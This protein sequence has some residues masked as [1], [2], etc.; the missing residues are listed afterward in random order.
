MSS[1]TPPVP[2]R[3]SCDLVNEPFSETEWLI[4]EI[5]PKNSL[6]LF[7]G[8]EGSMKTW[9]AL[10]WAFSVAEGTPWLTRECQ[11]AAVLYLDA[12]NPYQ[13]F[14]QRVGAISASQNWN[15]W[16]WQDP[17]FPVSLADSQLLA[18][19]QEHRLIIIDSLRR[20]MQ[21]REENSA[22]EMASI[23][24]QLR[25]LTREGATVL[26]LHHARK[27]S[28]NKGYR[29]STELGAGVDI[30]MHI[31]Q[32]ISSPVVDKLEITVSKTRYHEKRT[33]SLE[34]TTTSARPLFQETGSSSVSP[35]QASDT[36]LEEIAVIIEN[37][38]ASSEAPPTQTQIA[39]EAHLKGLGS[40]NTVRRRLSQGEGRYWHSRTNGRTRVYE[41]V[42]VSTCP[43]SGQVDNTSPH[44][45]QP[46]HVSNPRDGGQVDN[47]HPAESQPVQGSDSSD[48]EPM[49]TT[50]IEH[51]E[52][53]HLSNSLASG[54]VDNRETAKE[55]SV[56]LP[57]PSVIRKVDTSLPIHLHDLSNLSTTPVSGQVDTSPA[58]P[59]DDPGIGSTIHFLY[60]HG[61]F[62]QGL[63]ESILEWPGLPE[64]IVYQTGDGRCVPPSRVRQKSEGALIQ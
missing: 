62:S 48:L 8:R 38:L 63:I 54:H 50:P 35:A 56:H 5:L 1:T 53:V 51:P 41:P 23:T 6:I 13:V 30:C 16:R 58:I 26:V 64:D 14:R 15:V 59:L 27:D 57:R 10:D 21:D 36:E 44:Q 7:S 19:A 4:Q 46:V 39:D 61:Y 43:V 22:T 25:E 11:S 55:R 49:D 29:G 3:S 31:T 40:R 32:E 37:L 60:R 47:S 52:P 17:I 28:Q 20:F 45:N 2:W 9:L 34:S 12:E 33:I 24:K 18:A 42:H